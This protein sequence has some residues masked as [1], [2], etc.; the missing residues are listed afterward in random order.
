MSASLSGVFNL[1][2]FTDLGALMAGGRLYTYAPSTTTLKTA[3]TDAA[4]SVAHTYT[5]DGLGGQYIALN[6]RGELPAP[7]F[8]TSG[9]YD[10]TLKTSA[11]VT[12]WTRRAIGGADASA[13]VLAS[14]ASTANGAG[15]SLVG[16]Y[17]VGNYF[18]GTNLETVTTEIGQRITGQVS[19]LEKGGDPIG[20]ASSNSAITAAQGAAQTIIFTPGTWLVDANITITSN[21]VFMRGAKLS[22]A[23]GVTVTFSGGVEAGL[24]QIFSWAGTGAVTISPGSQLFAVPQWWG[25]DVAATAAT[26]TA[27]LNACA[28]ACYGLVIWVPRGAYNFNGM[29]IVPIALSG[30]SQLPFTLIGEGIDGNGGNGGTDLI[31]SAGAAHGID[32]TNSTSTNSDNSILIEGIHIIGPGGTASGGD[33]IHVVKCNNVI[34]RRCQVTQT[35][36]SGIYFERCYGGAIEN[37]T[38]LGNRLNGIWCY[39]QANIVRLKDIK[40]YNNGKVYSQVTGN[41]LFSGGVG[42]ESLGPVVDNVDVSY[43]GSNATRFKRSD[44]SLVSIVVAAGVATVTTLAAHGRTTGDMISVVGATVDANLNTTFT[45]SITVTGAT[46]FTFAT[47]AANGTYTE[48]TLVV[49]PAAYG[50]LM[51]NVQ[52]A[53]VYAYAEDCQGPA[54]YADGSV[55]SIDLQG[56][57]WQ[58]SSG[59]GLVLLDDPSR[60]EVGGMQFNGPFAK[61]YVGTSARPHGVNIKS[62]NTFGGG[63]TL[64]DA[65]VIKMRDGNYLSNAIPAAGTWGSNDSRRVGNFTPTVG[66]PKA[67]SRTVD[68]APGTWVSEGNL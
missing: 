57:Y 54:F 29:T 47:A 3:Y 11:G 67:W 62:S 58:G 48:S 59:S 31:L 27:A 33:G 63:A 50:L 25:F 13:S 49:G 9:G 24:W 37:S 2:S 19:I 56:G 42:F 7:L 51:Q 55:V 10:I 60:M 17:D 8:L 23:T 52:G 32:L 14:L 36:G 66:Q 43:S 20:G 35:G 68:G 6:S 45:K 61:L 40:A 53:R 34:I 64:V 39:Q 28:I 5:A 16:V 46:T 15:A 26:N 22:I 4:G 18:T 44:N 21:A 12:V 1:Q 65:G 41:V 38:L 30:T